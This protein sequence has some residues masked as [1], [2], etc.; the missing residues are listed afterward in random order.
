MAVKVIYEN[1]AV[2]ASESVVTSGTEAQPFVDYTELNNEEINIKN[3]GTLEG[4]AWKLSDD[5]SI[6]PDDLE[7]VDMGYWS[8]Q[9]SDEN[10]NFEN[11]I[12]LTRTYTGTFTAPGI[13]ITFDSYNN[14]YASELNVKW[15]RNNEVLHD[16]DFYP[17]NAIYFCQQNVVA[18]NKIEITFKK[19]SKPSRFL[20]IF[21]IDDGVSRHFYSDEIK[22]LEIYEEISDT[23][24]SLAINTMDLSILAKSDVKILFQRI[25][26]LKVYN[27]D[28][29][30]GTFFVESSSRT[31]NTYDLVT[32]DNV[33]MLENDN[34]I[35]GLYE[36]APVPQLIAE[37]CG[38][39]PYE[40]DE[41]FN[42]MTVTGYLPIATCRDSL[43]QVGFAIN[44]VIDTSR[45]EKVYIY[46]MPNNE[47]IDIDETR[48]N[49]NITE[50]MEAPFTSIEITEHKYIK[51][52]ETTEI[53]NEVLNG[54]VTLTFNEPYA[55]LS[56]TGGTI[57][58]SGTNYA[59]ITGSGSE[60]VLT[61]YGYTDVT[62]L[63]TS[64]NL[65]NTAN[66]IPNVKSIT[67]ATLVNS[68]NSSVIL[69]RLEKVLY[70]N[71]KIE[72][73][74]ILDKERVGDIINISTLEGIKTGRIIAMNFKLIGDT[75]YAYA[76][77]REEAING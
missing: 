62:T 33:G 1:K 3:Y 57:E 64:F 28:D 5:V 18:Y 20:K 41:S 61:G 77:I 66:T 32:Y 13:T 39:I 42:D 53:F 43:K 44:A 26:A 49:G 71:N 9:M 4:N 23:G 59:T 7:S 50:T 68:N 54:T 19:M 6:F 31:G 16:V 55:N 11:E 2:G 58:A 30:F 60:V 65:T 56:I 51:N 72:V 67:N 34:Y 36:N 24:E 37:I 45:G 63:K 10:G 22:G 69:N 46:P 76:T 21:K 40:L 52:N 8:V 75:I 17:N 70:I 25:Q 27:N 35:G 47:A 74:F 73:S 15:Y 14:E 12:V 38:D 48:A 29:L